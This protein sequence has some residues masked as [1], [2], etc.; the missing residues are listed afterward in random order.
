MRIASLLASG[1]EFLF[2][3]GLGESVVAVSHECNFPPEA[4]ERPRVT[5]ALVDAH[6]D[7]ADIDR[8]VRERV[9]A[10]KPLYAIDVDLLAELRPDLIVTQ[11][12]CEVCAVHYEDV[13][14]TVADVAALRH[15]RVVALNPTS[16]EEVF[17]DILRV[18]AAA[19][20]EQRAEEYVRRLKGRVA[21]VREKCGAIPP[22][23][24]PRTVFIEWT[25][26]LMVGANWMP[27]M[28]EIAGG[29]PGISRA[30]DRS[31]ATSW[32]A[33]VRF[34]PEVLVIAPCGFDLV[35]ATAEAGTLFSRPGWDSLAAV[36]SDRVYAADGD[37]FF[38]RSG[39][40][41]VD[42]LELLASMMHPRSILPPARSAEAFCR[43]VA[44]AASA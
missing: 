5:R 24:R 26:P 16:L 19:G 37:A 33:I 22:T 29:I 27:E 18:G 12:Q 7:S 2:E 9:A 36:R 32:D 28:I 11:A 44:S 34:D 31:Q 43:L 3:L 8:E 39:P 42:S 17:R 21:A 4:N 10:G 1:T 38:N 25:D 30:G 23:L 6:A 41:I 40:R 20:V 14:R 13:L 15:A 35:R